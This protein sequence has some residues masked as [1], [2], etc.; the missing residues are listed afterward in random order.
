MIGPQQTVTRFAPSP[1]GL[2]HLGHAYSALF[3][4]AAAHKLE[5]SFILRIEDIDTGRCRPEFETAIMEDLA[6]LGLSWPEPVRR[7]AD[8]MQDYAQALDRLAA[9]G[10]LYRCVLSRKEMDQALSA[11]HAA[12]GQSVASGYGPTVRDS[13]RLLPESERARR[14]EAG[15]PYAWRL[16]LRDAMAIAGPLTWRDLDAGT[17]SA[18]PQIFGDV[19]LARK[20]VGTSYHLSVTVDDALQGVTLVTRG[21]DLFPATHVHRLL[22]HLLDLPTPDYQ[23]HRMLVDAAGRRYAKRDRALALRN[24]RDAGYSLRD[25]KRMVG[26]T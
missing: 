10:L 12:H 5:G 2:L 16:R 18:T 4:A 21:E 13:D 20:D 7:Q 14:L 19:V 24:L 8:H 22:Q 17:Q 11:P 23:H 9:M 26:L 25:I 6:W 15:A 1:S 3:A